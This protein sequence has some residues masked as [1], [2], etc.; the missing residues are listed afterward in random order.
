MLRFVALC[1][2]WYSQITLQRS[3]IRF[4]GVGRGPPCGQAAGLSAG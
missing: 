1:V 3:M 2:L 4:D